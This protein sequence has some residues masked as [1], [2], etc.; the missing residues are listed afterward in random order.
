MY[1]DDIGL[2]FVIPARCAHLCDSWRAPKQGPVVVFVAWIRL[3]QGGVTEHTL[4]PRARLELQR[5]LGAGKAEFCWEC[6]HRPRSPWPAAR[7]PERR[8]RTSPVLS[9]KSLCC[10][11]V[12]SGPLFRKAVSLS[13]TVSP[14][15]Q[16][17]LDMFPTVLIGCLQIL[18]FLFQIINVLLECRRLGGYVT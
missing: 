18:E 14:R 1:C 16:D 13:S 11:S 10:M 15:L 5:Q 17:L 4:A 2:V 9:H 6:Y 8:W 7:T 12:R 3:S